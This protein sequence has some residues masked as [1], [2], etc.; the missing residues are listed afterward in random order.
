MD[1]QLV[2]PGFA[3]V[4]QAAKRGLRIRRYEFADYKW[5]VIKPMLTNKP[6]GVPRVNAR[7]VLNVFSGCRDRERPSAICRSV[8][9]VRHLRQLP[10]SLAA[11]WCPEP[12]HRRSCRF[13][14]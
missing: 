8:R 2:N 12:Y 5:S 9:P 14:R 6:P 13:P 3:P 11:D 10:R 7:R 1:L 4:I